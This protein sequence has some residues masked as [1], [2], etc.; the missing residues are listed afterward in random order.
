[1]PVLRNAEA[2][3][4][5]VGRG[6]GRVMTGSELARR[7]GKSRSTV[8]HLLNGRMVSCTSELASAIEKTLGAPAGVIFVTDEHGAAIRPAA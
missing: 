5:Y 4:S 8:D 7:I 3:R 2:L 6:P 1:M